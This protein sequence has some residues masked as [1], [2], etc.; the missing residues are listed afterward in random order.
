MAR[1]RKKIAIS[2]TS[3]DCA[4]GLHCFRATTEMIRQDRVGV[5]R[6]C[7]AKLVDWQRVHKCDLTDVNYTFRALKYE[8]IRHHFWHKPLT[9]RATNH[10]RRKGKRVL[11]L[12]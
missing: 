7:G 5:C 4:G 3:T 12:H 2:C 9:Q 1:K 8:C 10:A 6:E 11:R